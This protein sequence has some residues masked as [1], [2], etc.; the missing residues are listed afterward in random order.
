MTSANSGEAAYARLRH[1]VMRLELAPAAAVSEAQLVDGF[2][3]SKA[4]VRAALARLRAE[5]LVV[6]E[7]RRGHFIA[8]LTMRDVLDIY[9]LRL[10]LEPPA[11]EAAAARISPDELARLQ[12]L[13]EPPVNVDDAESMEQFL[14]ANRAIHLALVEAAG[15]RRAAQ[16]VERLLDDSERARLMALRAGAA[17]GG[18][19]AREELANVLAELQAGDGARAAQLMAAA[20]GTF[21]DELVESLQRA[22]L[23]LPLSV[24]SG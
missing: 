9:H 18:V 17:S 16:I 8:P 1:A 21:R 4:S 13:A 15:N 11:T 2:G 23:D 3:F 5:G 19:R 7:P 22:S 12:V 14:S 10:L 20:I 6:A 24:L